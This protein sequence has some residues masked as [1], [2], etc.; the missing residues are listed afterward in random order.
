[1]NAIAELKSV[2][3]YYCEGSSD[4][5]YHVRI[6]E[7]GSGFLVNFAYGRRGATLSTGTKT[8]SP[9]TLE[10]AER[11]YDKLV[12]EK[13]S[14]GYTE[15]E[16][17][18]PY[19]HSDNEE[20]HEGL[21]PQLLNTVEEADL[22]RLLNDPN[23]FMQEKLDGRRM[24]LEKHGEHIIPVNKKGFAISA[25]LTIRQSAERLKFD[26]VLDGESI[27]DYLHVFDLLELDGKDLQQQSY[28]ERYIALLNLIAGSHTR[29][30]Q[31]VQ[32]FTSTKDKRSW[33][34]DLQVKRAEG[35]VFKDKRAPYTPGRPNSGGT[36]LKHK[37]VATLS[38]VVTTINPQRSVTVS[39]LDTET[40][41]H[42]VGNVTIP[43]N[44]KVPACG[45]V[46]EIRYL[47]AFTQSRKLFQPVYLGERQDIDPIECTMT[48]LKFKPDDEG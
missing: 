42:P 36:Q 10:A 14:K 22:D 37:F 9:V 19:Q 34:R 8:T 3:L 21:R 7:S 1:M 44:H 24:L 2:S 12:K 20:N 6:Q 23:W 25:P 15:G 28:E 29:H 30:I 26:C 13:K 33:F 27:G 4:K 47:H 48:Q 38:A 17:G 11:L 41:W 39:L 32:C 35:V 5:E 46:V 40:G 45:C 18:T 43:A 31:I 16:S